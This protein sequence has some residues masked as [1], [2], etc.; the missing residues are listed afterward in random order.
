MADIF[1]S[2]SEKDRDA[3]DR[4]GAMLQSVGWSVWWDRRI[5]AG[6]TWRDVLAQEMQSMRCMVVLWS[7]HSVQSEWVSEE[8]AEG[9]SLGRLVPVS[10]ERVRPPA[11]FRE[12]QAADLIDWD[13]SRD[14]A[15]LQRLIEDITRLI[16]KPGARPSQPPMPTPASG[17]DI[18]YT[19]A[20]GPSSRPASATPSAVPRLV[21]WGATALLLLIGVGVYLGTA[22]RERVDERKTLERLT[23]VPPPTAP[24]AV[25]ASAVM[26]AKPAAPPAIAAV[27]TTS[28]PGKRAATRAPVGVK[29]G[30]ATTSTVSA[31]CTALMERLE[32]G[33]PLSSESQLFL[34]KECP[35]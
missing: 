24:P 17:R 27:V 14:F 34:R 23:M 8:A 35:P 6:M 29:N 12:I 9:R 21:S 18:P 7:T 26:P 22:W 10:I 11:G 2:Y 33:E 30:P 25:G 20:D 32:L 28:P 3:V 1:M 5:P 15:G 4:L 13:G 31:R 19:D 16:G